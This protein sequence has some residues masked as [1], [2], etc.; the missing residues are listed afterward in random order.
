[1]GWKTAATPDGRLSGEE[2]SKN[3][4]SVHGMNRAGATGAI[5]SLAKLDSSLC[6]GDFPVDIAL[7]PGAVQGEDGLRAMEGL[8]KTYMA[9]YGHAIHFNVFSAE[10]LRKAQEE[11]EKYKDLQIRV[12]GWNVLW[13]SLSPDEQKFYIRQAEAAQ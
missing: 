13:N 10:T 7:N 6:M 8:L 2:C 5:A 12:C 11:P 3:A 1:M 4:T 9:N